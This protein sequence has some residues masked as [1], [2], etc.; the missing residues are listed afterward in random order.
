MNGPTNAKPV[1]PNHLFA[2]LAR[3]KNGHDKL[4]LQITVS[5][6]RPMFGIYEECVKGVCRIYQIS[7]REWMNEYFNLH[8]TE[9]HLILIYKGMINEWI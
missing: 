1:C 9:W 3:S 7:T 5:D 6:S 4:N 2:I 8:E